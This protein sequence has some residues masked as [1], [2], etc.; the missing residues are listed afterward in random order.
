MDDFCIERIPFVAL[1]PEELD[2]H[3]L[4]MDAG[5]KLLKRWADSLL[6]KRKRGEFRQRLFAGEFQ[7]AIPRCEYTTIMC[8]RQVEMPML[9]GFSKL[10]YS[11]A[12]RW[13]KYCQ[14]YGDIV[15]IFQDL[16]QEA[17]L[18]FVDIVYTY[19]H[20]NETKFI[21]YAFNC[22]DNHLQRMVAT[23]KRPLLPPSADGAREL[24]Y[25]YEKLRQENEHL[26]LDE[27]AELM[28]LDA[29]QQFIMSKALAATMINNTDFHDGGS[30]SHDFYDAHQD[31]NSHHDYTGV[32]ANQDKLCESIKPDFDEMERVHDAIKLANLSDFESDLLMASTQSDQGW[33]AEIARQHHKSR[34]AATV[35]FKRA[36]KKVEE[37]YESK[38]G[39]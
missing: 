35:A 3:L 7:T 20:G 22:L 8:V 34:Y 11:R 27:A 25:K 12:A 5:N 18:K 28:G 23:I 36:C 31:F 10:I 17:S 39:E 26:T 14:G 29:E 15:V 19:E 30:S 38:Y 2:G 9:Q 33:K 24:V 6:G 32:E 13:T 16:Y 1:S 37:V 21:T 4:V